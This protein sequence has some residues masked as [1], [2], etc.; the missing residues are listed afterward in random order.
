MRKIYEKLPVWVVYSV[1]FAFIVLCTFGSLRLMGLTTIWK[2][3]G[4]AQ[5]YPILKQFYRI[6]H[7]TAHQ[8]LFGWSWNLGLG[9]D[10]MTTFAYYVVGDPFSYLI[11]L[12]PAGKIQLGYQL[13]TIL[14]LYVVGLAFLVFAKQMKLKRSG[15]LVGSLIYTFTSFSFYV[16]FHHPFFLLPLIFFPLL[17]TAVDKIYHGQSFLWLVAITAIVLISNI[18]FAYLLGIGSLIFALIR[19]ADLKRK[20]ELVRPFAKSFGYFMLTVVMALLISAMVLLPNIFSMLNSSRSSG[21]SIFANGLKLYPGAYYM[22]LPNTLLD[23]SGDRLYWAVIG[24]SGVS[25][26]AMMWTLRHFKQYLMLNITLILIVVGMLLPQFAAV[27]NVM[28]TPSN[29]WL[30]LAQIVF[31]LAAGI[32][33]DHL[34]ELEPADFK[35]FLWG[36]LIFFA[37]IWIGNGFGFSMRAH[38]LVTYGIYLLTLVIIAYGLFVGLNNVRFRL[39]L[40]LLIT[41]NVISIGLGFYNSSYNDRLQIGE[42]SG[43]VADH[44]IK[45]YFDYADRYL[46]RTDKTFYRTA[47]TSNYYSSKAVGNNIPMLLNTHTIGSYFSVQS[48]AVNDFN[49]NLQNN[50][51]TMNNPTS[52]VDNRTTMSSL[53]NVKYLFVRHNQVG[54]SKVPYG[55]EI[56]KNKQGKPM[57][58]VNRPVYKLDNQFGT[59]IYRN[60]YALPLAY[61][62]TRQLDSAAFQRLSANNKEQALLDGT[63]TSQKLTGV[64]TVKATQTAQT[65]PYSVEMNYQPFT[66]V[67][68]ATKYRIKRDT[69]APVTNKIESKKLTPKQIKYYDYM[70]KFSKPSQSVRNLLQENQTIVDQN[71]YDNRNGLK[72]MTS[73]TLGQNIDYKITLKNPSA[74][75]NCELYIEFDGIKAHYPTISDRLNYAARRSEVADIPFSTGV[76]L[77]YWR[78][79]S[80]N[81]YFN[82]FNLK[83]SAKH[84]KAVVQQLGISNMSDYEKKGKALVNL[85]YAKKARKTINV[86][87]TKANHMSFKHVR[88]IAVPFG[89]RYRQKTT[90]IQKQSLRQL[91]V[92]NDGVTGTTNRAQA[93][94]LTTSIPYTKGWHLTVDGQATPTQKVNTGFVGAKLPAGRH[95]VKLTYR[96]PGLFAGRLLSILGLLLLV[97]GAAVEFWRWLGRTQ[98]T[99]H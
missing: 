53:L 9:A 68:Q 8:S 27:M 7:G 59:A 73:D 47:S 69:S 13:L 88:I 62:Q 45:A 33:V 98:T 85:G 95:Q 76:K 63:L 75:K 79:F 15:R 34:H 14:R 1:F 37:L 64:K 97:V 38:H 84:K 32:F 71:N 36:T 83:V 50:E 61:T 23:S 51:N 43:G 60:K 48:G 92:T 11:A 17:C 40:L 16:A 4:I 2:M 72:K 74:Y 22:K 93:S 3:D 26:I 70:S 52:N 31:A 89:Q 19:Y 44:W 96:T 35:W 99:K 30:L 10:Q 94:I 12:F 39:G 81:Q 54:K 87:V 65:V 57:D 58:F 41:V 28:S 67:A 5:H 29:R 78:D 90:Q 77:N 18:Y 82:S 49:K 6:L 24:T 55:F 46:N 42:L 25:L 20:G 21:A 80:N 56:M 66:T 86:S 91:K